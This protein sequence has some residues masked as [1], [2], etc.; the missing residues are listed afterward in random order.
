[1]LV[2]MVLLPS[3]RNDGLGQSAALAPG[4]RFWLGAGGAAALTF[5][6][7]PWALLTIAA[8][9]AAMMWLAWQQIQGQTGDVL[10][11]TQKIAEALA[12]MTAAATII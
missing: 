6:V 1:M 7:L 4:W 12:W 8:G 9:T 11:A 10:G 3:A 5:I 2:P